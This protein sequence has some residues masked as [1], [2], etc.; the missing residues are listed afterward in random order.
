MAVIAL[1]GRLLFS[2]V[3]L[4]SGL[5]HL[6]NADAMTGYAEAKG[7]PLPRASVVLSGFVL[8]FAG[9]GLAL[10]LWLEIATWVLAI[11]LL[12]TAFKFHDYW[13]VED[14][15]TRAGEQAHFLKDLALA[16]ALVLLYAIVQTAG[17][18]ALTVGGP[19]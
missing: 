19:M 9:L 14:A 17:Y 7:M 6:K 8:L 2:L 1:V 11:F 4:I 5:N 3:F 16:G 10:G 12:V 15:Q 13:N 18:P